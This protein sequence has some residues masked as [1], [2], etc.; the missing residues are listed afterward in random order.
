MVYAAAARRRA[1]SPSTERT[2]TPPGQPKKPGCI[3]LLH[4][5]STPA[6][7]APRLASPSNTPPNPAH[8]GEHRREE[9]RSTAPATTA[10]TRHTSRNR[11]THAWA[12]HQEPAARSRRRHPTAPRGPPREPPPQPAAPVV[13]PHTFTLCS[14]ETLFCMMFCK[15][16]LYLFFAMQLI[17]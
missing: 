15:F 14:G 10:T 17:L 4:L 12:P 8:D 9:H 1:I 2:A 6:I 3:L 16:T 11:G 5:A 13:F 7:P